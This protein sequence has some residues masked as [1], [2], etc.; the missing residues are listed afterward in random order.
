MLRQQ[1]L[2]NHDC[3]VK[4]KL[5]TNGRQALNRRRI[6]I[7]MHIELRLNQSLPHCETLDCPP[8]NACTMTAPPRRFSLLN[9]V[10]TV[11]SKLIS[12]L[13]SSSSTCSQ[14]SQEASPYDVRASK[15]QGAGQIG[16]DATCPER[17]RR[18][19]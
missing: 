19:F 9:A 11:S 7:F 17:A 3:D 16:S 1:F 6:L 8:C 15:H 14:K 2:L 5:V 18:R 13:T 10:P 4:P 12:F